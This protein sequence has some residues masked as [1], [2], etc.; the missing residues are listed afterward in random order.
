MF[1]WIIK[2]FMCM[3]NYNLSNKTLF[4]EKLIFSMYKTCWA[5]FPSAGPIS[6]HTPLEGTLDCTYPYPIFQE[7]PPPPGKFNSSSRSGSYTSPCILEQEPRCTIL[8][9]HLPKCK[10]SFVDILCA[11][12]KV[13]KEIEGKLSL[14]LT[15]KSSFVGS[16]CPTN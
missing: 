1:S 13:D 16:W 5:N 10:P 4:F 2:K 12:C 3:T 8:L 14:K 7:C 6:R 15:L 9:H 11:A